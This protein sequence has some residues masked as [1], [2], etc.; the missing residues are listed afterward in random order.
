MTFPL[1]YQDVFD[2]KTCGKRWIA[3][4]LGVECGRYNGLDI[5]AFLYS[6]FKQD[7]VIDWVLILLPHPI[8]MQGM[9]EIH[10][11]SDTSGGTADQSPHYKIVLVSSFPFPLFLLQLWSP[12]TLLL[13]RRKQSFAKDLCHFVCYFVSLVRFDI[14]LAPNWF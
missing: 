8:W 1:G 7:G 11:S 12:P 2:A 13:D 10:R 14:L 5:N 4:W 3:V 6:A 9:R